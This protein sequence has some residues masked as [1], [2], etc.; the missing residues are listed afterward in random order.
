[1]EIHKY[2]LL[3][4][5]FIFHWVYILFVALYVFVRKNKKYDWIFGLTLSFLIAY[6]MLGGYLE[7]KNLDDTYKFGQHLTEHPSLYL[8]QSNMYIKL[9][10]AILSLLIIYNMFMML[11]IYKV[12]SIVK[13]T[14]SLGVFFYLVYYRIVDYISMKVKKIKEYP[15]PEWIT[16]STFLKGIYDKKINAPI[17][18]IDTFNLIICHIMSTCLL[19][20]IDWTTFEEHC[21]ILRE[22]A[23]PDSYDYVVGIESGGAFIGRLMRK[24][25]KYIKISKYDDNP[26]FLGKPHIKTRDDL[27]M[28][29]G[30]TVLVVDDQTLT[31]ETIKTAKQYLM[32][33]CGARKVDTGILYCRTTK[34]QAGVDYVGM[35]YV[36]VQSPW[37]FS[38]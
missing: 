27:S 9:V 20:P 24:D 10:M 5:L 23:N 12:P 28:L 1:M 14:L 11:T 4:L 16:E 35:P 37:G 6:W 21:A 13:W 26:N 8:Y 30:K 29:R 7:N 34:E 22:K 31:G 15:L 36:I 17:T 19:K 33:V 3:G 32:E 18:Y 38:A 2:L 25:C